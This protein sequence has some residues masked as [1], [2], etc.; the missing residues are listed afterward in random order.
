MTRMKGYV[1]M[2]NSEIDY[3]DLYTLLRYVNRPY[4]L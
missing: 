4:Q 3:I 2:V 1:G